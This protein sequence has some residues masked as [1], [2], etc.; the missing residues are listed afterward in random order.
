MSSHEPK[1]LPSEIQVELQGLPYHWVIGK[2]HWHLRIGGDFVAIW[3][4]GT[5]SS[6]GR[7]QPWMAAR[8]SIRK[9]KKENQRECG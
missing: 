1:K 3:P 7:R 8:A 4:R 2:K 5:V 6:T 9:W